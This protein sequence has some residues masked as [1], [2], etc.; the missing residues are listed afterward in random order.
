VAV[1]PRIRDFL[2]ELDQLLDAR[3]W[4]DLERDAADA[5]TGD[6]VA[7]VRLVHRRDHAR[8]IEL[9]IDDHEVRVS[10]PPERIPFRRRDEALRFVEMLGDGR[11]TLHVHHGLVVMTLE[12]YRD[13]LAQ[14]FR[15]SRVLLPTLKP[16]T[17]V[18]QYGFA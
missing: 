2:V 13:G 4:P 18:R 8:D 17:E 10:Y 12:S 14:P 9:E 15:R 3:A 5:T 7:L 16:R 1:T 6:A 11:I